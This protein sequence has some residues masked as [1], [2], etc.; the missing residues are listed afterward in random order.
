MVLWLPLQLFPNLIKL[1]SDNKIDD[2]TVTWNIMY[3]DI[4]KM[5][6]VYSTLVYCVLFKCTKSYQKIDQTKSNQNS[7]DQLL[8]IMPFM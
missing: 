4:Y 5:W 1:Y 2:M 7:L 8:E 3:D 6:N